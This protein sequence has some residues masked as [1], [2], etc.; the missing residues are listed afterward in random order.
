MKFSRWTFLFG[1]G[2]ALALSGPVT[3]AQLKLDDE[4]P[5]VLTATVE[6][7]AIAPPERQIQM[8]VF[9]PEPATYGLIG[10]AGLVLLLL[11]RRV[12][13]RSAALA[14]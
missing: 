4:V 13:T 11:V 10:A 1:F 14:G 5:R 8:A 6:E 7:T 3:F 2:A 12:L 9:I